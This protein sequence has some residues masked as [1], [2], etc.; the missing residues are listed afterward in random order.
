MS[1]LSLLLQVPC[2][3]CKGIEAMQAAVSE[4]GAVGRSPVVSVGVV[5]VCGPRVW[6]S[7]SCRSPF[8]IMR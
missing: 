4:M 7:L 6:H 2:F 1:R 5:S 8:E 3:S